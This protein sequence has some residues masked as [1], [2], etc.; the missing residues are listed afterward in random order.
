MDFAKLRE[1]NISR[2]NLYALISRLMMI[3]VD[4]EFLSTIEGDEY[5]M[6]L[7]PNYR[8]WGKRKEFTQEKIINEYLNVDYTSLFLMHMVP[9][10][11]FY[12][13]DD[14]MVESGGDN[15]VIEL[16]NSLDFRV[17]LGKARIVSADHIGVELE[18]IY[19][20]CNA[21][22]K[23]I[24]AKDSEGVCEL[25]SVQRGFMRD[26]LLQWAPMFLINMRRE[27]RTPLYHD[28]SELTMEFLLSDYEYLTALVGEVCN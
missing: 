25:L 23:A 6:E 10:E 21:I 24:E 3:E 18:F 22:D 7:L 15:P 17:D 11:S 16:Y 13:R 2:T 26:H 28:A 12:R 1:E 9:Y 14:Q 8:D 27:S 19:M 20:L 4:S 5:I